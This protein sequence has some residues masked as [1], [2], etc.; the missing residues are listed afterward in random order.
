MAFKNIL[1]R[2][3]LNFSI[4]L[5]IILF[6]I[7]HIIRPSLVYNKDGSYRQFGVGYREKTII[8]IWVVSIVLAIFC[9]IFVHLLAYSV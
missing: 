3:V 6:T 9:Y 2:Y 4:F 7:I 5:F 1:K 8:S